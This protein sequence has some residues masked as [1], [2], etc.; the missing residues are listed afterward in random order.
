MK[1][2]LKNPPAK[3]L[4]RPLGSGH[5][6][7]SAIGRF[8]EKVRVAADGCWVWIGARHDNGNGMFDFGGRCISCAHRFSYQ[9][10]IDSD[11]EGL[12]LQRVC[13]NHS[14]V[15]PMHVAPWVKRVKVKPEPRSRLREFCKRGH[16]LTVESTYKR[17]GTGKR[18]CKA[19]QS[20]RAH[21]Y[22]LRKTTGGHH[23]R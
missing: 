22:Y 7:G 3:K 20:M 6:L 10:F 16:A 14:C 5:A 12:R 1:L 13:K 21:E 11:I 8:L 15:N 23:G 18:V 2:F 4:G 9:Y 17:R 19:C